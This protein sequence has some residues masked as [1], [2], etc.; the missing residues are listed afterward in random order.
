MEHFS[1]NVS[2]AL[3]DF[4]Y[5]DFSSAPYDPAQMT[6]DGFNEAKMHF[7]NV[8]FE[9]QPL[10]WFAWG[11]YV[12]WDIREGELDRI[13]TWFDFLTD[14]LGFRFIVEYENSYDRIDGY[15]QEDDWS[16]GFYVYLRA[17]GADS[18]NI[19]SRNR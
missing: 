6:E 19:L 13:G 11:P 8:G 12:R 5:W 3:R 10:D 18:G 14:C 15:V 2:Y 16:F 9:N 1:Y 7:I 17:F 4:R